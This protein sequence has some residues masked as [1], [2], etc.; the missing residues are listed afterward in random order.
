MAIPKKVTFEGSKYN[1][2]DKD[3][4]AAAVAVNKS[5]VSISFAAGAGSIAG[6]AASGIITVTTQSTVGNDITVTFAD[7]PAETPVCTFT[8]DLT[9]LTY[10]TIVGN[11][12]GFTIDVGGN[13]GTGTLHY[14]CI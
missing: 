2:D 1:L 13:T 14:V 9:N 5:A 7:P 12:N 3:R 6:D 10:P 8:T 11:A 4:V